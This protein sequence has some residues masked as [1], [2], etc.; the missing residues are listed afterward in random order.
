VSF[1]ENMTSERRAASIFFALM[2]VAVAVAGIAEIGLH[3][4]ESSAS[5]VLNLRQP[6]LDQILRVDRDLHEAQIALSVARHAGSQNMRRLGYEQYGIHTA[7]VLERLQRTIAGAVDDPLV[8]EL[9]AT[10]LDEQHAWSASARAVMQ[11]IE[12]NADSEDV[13]S[14]WADAEAEF[15]FLSRLVDQVA[16]AGVEPLV[17][18][19]R[20][21]LEARTVAAKV[22]IGVAV[23]LGLAISALY[24]VLVIRIIK[25]RKQ[26][27]DLEKDYRDFD[28]RMQRALQ[29]IETEPEVLDI[30]H[31]A[32]DQVLGSQRRAELI[33]ADSSRS[34]VKRLTSSSQGEQ[35]QGCQVETPQDC[36]TMRRNTRMVFRSNRSFEAC[37]HLRHDEDEACSA[38][39]VPVSVMG[40]TVGVLH[41]LGPENTQPTRDELRRLDSIALKAGDKLGLVR[42]FTSKDV[43]ANTDTL[44]GLYN[45][46]ALEAQV[47]LVME[48]NKTFSVAYGDLDHFKKL[49][50]VHGH[51]IGDRAIRLFAEVLRTTLRPTDLFA[52]WGGEEFV[53]ILP[54]SNMHDSLRVLERLRDKL[55]ERVAIS[56]LPPFTA[57]FGVSDS[58]MANDFE[59][60]VSRADEALLRAKRNGRDRVERDGD[61]EESDAFVDAEL[62]AGTAQALAADS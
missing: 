3:R 38:T 14:L 49:N 32:L 10:A 25:R 41:T 34:K 5:N 52:R 36:P 27:E 46:R 28:R 45:R 12:A 16:T 20:A 33:V 37:P 51:D 18:A 11:A 7:R 54:G 15:Q 31:D 6:M 1:L 57:S 22:S 39:C 60:I 24:V 17:A 61:W 50:D 23:I 48:A 21:E 58:S 4:I 19:G 29:L 43:L 59:T 30:V 55:K 26:A 42:T 47:P 44:T 13:E 53:I 35:W 40:H 9:A 56:R 2:W 8:A 62:A